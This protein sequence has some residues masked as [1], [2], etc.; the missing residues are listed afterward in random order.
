M[1]N[2]FVYNEDRE[3][4][5]YFDF[6]NLL[7][8][9]YYYYCEKNIYKRIYNT[10]EESIRTIKVFSEP[11]YLHYMVIAGEHR[12]SHNSLSTHKYIQQPLNKLESVNGLLRSYT[13]N[14]DNI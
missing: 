4:S 6:D 7:K 14:I 13:V 12:I 3:L 1:R 9:N 10:D 11:I 8:I 2:V 5:E